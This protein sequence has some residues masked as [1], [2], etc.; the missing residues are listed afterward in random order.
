MEELRKKNGFIMRAC[1]KLVRDTCHKCFYN[2]PFS[3]IERGM[4][5]QKK[6]TKNRHLIL[7]MYLLILLT[8]ANLPFFPAL[9][10]QLIEIRN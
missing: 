3:S 1:A 8:L 4:M 5:R 2:L 9:A 7:N 6:T 10:H